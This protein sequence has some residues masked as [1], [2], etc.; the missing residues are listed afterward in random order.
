MSP[1][2]GEVVTENNQRDVQIDVR[3]RKEILYYEGEPRFE[4]KFA[5]QAIED[6]P[7]LELVTLQRTA[8][9]KYLRLD[10]DAAGVELAA[11][12]PKTREELF[13]YRGIVLGSV[14]ASAFTADQ[15]RMISEFVDVRGGGLLVLGGARAFA[16][17]GY[18]GT[19]IAE[20]HAGRHR[21]VG[22]RIH[23]RQGASDPRRRGACGHAARRHR[24]GVGRALEDHAVAH[25]GEPD[26]DGQAG[27][28]GA[29]LRRPTIGT[30]SASCSPTSATAAASRSRSRCRTRGSGRCTRRSASRIRRTRISG[31]RCCAGWWTAC[32]TS[33]R[34]GTLTDRVE[35]GQPVDADR[36]RRRSAVRRAERRE[37]RRARDVAVRAGSDVPLQWTGERNGQYRATLP[38]RPRAGGTRAKVEATR[39]GKTVGTGG[40]ARPHGA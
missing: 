12:F 11:G 16:E 6:D 35:A 13:A 21:Q 3:D 29:A 30:A 18:A 39:D 10:V 8:E 26:R 24:A 22:A 1:Q 23:A 5:R 36:R 27:R 33:S 14:E 2:P 32:P 20:V 37:R 34:R 9:N 17:G 4:M 40:H 25:D 28:D 31:G 19:P 15:L 38:D 7:N